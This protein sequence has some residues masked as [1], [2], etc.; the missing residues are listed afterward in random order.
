M[1]ATVLHLNTERGWRGGEAQTLRLA[2][3]LQ[4]RGYRNLLVAQPGSPLAERAVAGGLRVVPLSM[5]GELDLPAAGALAAL[6][7]AERVDLLHYHTAHAVSLGTLATLLAGRRRA[8][9]ARRVSF[10]LR[11]RLLGRVK[12]S[13]R[14]DRVVA[15]SEAIRRALVAQGL[16]AER[17]VVVHSGI[18]PERFAS[19][20]R[21]RFRA[22]LAR[23]GDLPEG[24]FLIG[25]AGHLASH[26]G[27]DRF[28]EAAAQVAQEIGETRFVVV[29][30]GPR[31]ADLRRAAEA[32]PLRG[33]VLFAGF[34]EGMP[35][36]YAG[37]DLFVLASLSGEG[38]PA[39]LKEAMAAGVPLVATA[40][41]GI[42]EIVE[43]GRHGLLAPPGNVPALARA[44]ALLAAD[45][46]LRAELSAAARN[47]VREF[48][49]ERMVERTEAVYRSILAAA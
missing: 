29:G 24:A 14:V 9:A 12:Y 26:K 23:L 8:V 13:F 38:S 33:R 35:D 21:A 7:R 27:I 42:E 18:D 22:A 1:P 41:G 20:D 15:V 16:A 40:V 5:R 30:S 37:L 34:Q 44:M 4:A 47:H 31:E 19:G 25:T 39:V 6:L 3:G 2:Q 43:D 48:T 10:P 36:V 45:P 46:T 32:G 17:V 28:L 11:G 49:N